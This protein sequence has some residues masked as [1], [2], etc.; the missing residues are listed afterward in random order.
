MGK[1]RRERERRSDEAVGAVVQHATVP[2]PSASEMRDEAVGAVV[3]HAT[4]PS[5]SEMRDEA[6]GAVASRAT[7]PRASSSSARA[8]RLWALPVAPA[9]E[10][11]G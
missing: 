1:R 9:Q 5:A 7:V 10:T 11:G 8:L 2:V 6:M 4:A 3:Q